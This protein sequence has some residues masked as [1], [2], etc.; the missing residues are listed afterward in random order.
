[1]LLPQDDDSHDNDN[2]NNEVNEWQ[3]CEVMEM[4]LVLR[5]VMISQMYTYP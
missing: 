2:S 4:S 5:V 1:M 3:L